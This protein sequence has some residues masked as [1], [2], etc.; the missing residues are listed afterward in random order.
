MSGSSPATTMSPINNENSDLP[1]CTFNN[2]ECF[3]SLCLYSNSPLL[4][5]IYQTELEETPTQTRFPFCR[6]RSL[7]E[8]PHTLL[9]SHREGMHS[10]HLTVK[11]HAYISVL[12]LKQMSLNNRCHMCEWILSL[13]TV[14][15]TFNRSFAFCLTVNTHFRQTVSSPTGWATNSLC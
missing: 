10:S 9:S 14:L 8:P 15:Y 6:R 4:C 11:G 3:G 2:T 1:I 7:E 5:E 13:L 12:P